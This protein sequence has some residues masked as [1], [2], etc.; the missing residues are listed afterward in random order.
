MN[1]LINDEVKLT[2]SIIVFVLVFSCG[3]GL[4]DFF[5]RNRYQSQ[6]QSQRGHVFLLT[7]SGKINLG[8]YKGEHS[9]NKTV[10]IWVDKNGSKHMTTAAVE[11][12]EDVRVGEKR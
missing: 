9:A 10:S 7:P 3:V 11:F 8:D 12:I 2:A 6:Y 1:K 5:I 4:I